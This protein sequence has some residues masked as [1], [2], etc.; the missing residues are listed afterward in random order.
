MQPKDLSDLCG[1]L[2]AVAVAREFPEKTHHCVYMDNVEGGYRATKHLIEHGHR[3]IAIITGIARHPDAIKRL[4]GYEKALVEAGIKPDPELIIEGDF[5]ADSGRAAVESLLKN[6]KEFTA[7]FA[8]NDMMAF[9]ARLALYREDLRVPE[10]VSIVGFDDQAESAFMA[11]PLTTIRQPGHEMGARASKA[12]LSLI[13]GEPFESH[14][15]DGELQI[16]ESVAKNQ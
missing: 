11:P 9:G 7:I 14:R 3:K 6:K 8:G 2:P 5:L 16:R 13:A 15:M 12:I 10:D 4:E 1:P